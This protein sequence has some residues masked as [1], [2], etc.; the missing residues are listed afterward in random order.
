MSKSSSTETNI[1]VT[2]VL[3]SVCLLLLLFNHADALGSP[4]GVFCGWFVREIIN[5]RSINHD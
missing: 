4:F 3:I 2:I 5:S 1:A